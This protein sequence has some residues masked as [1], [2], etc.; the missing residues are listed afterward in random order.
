MPTSVRYTGGVPR[1]HGSACSRGPQ[2]I[3]FPRVPNPAEKHWTPHLVVAR[4]PIVRQV[5]SAL[6]NISNAS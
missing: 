1:C 4:D 3:S 2:E 6:F 5:P